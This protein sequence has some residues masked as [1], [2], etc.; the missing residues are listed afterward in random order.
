MSKE[1]EFLPATSEAWVYLS[2][3]RVMLKRLAREQV[4]PDFHYRQLPESRLEGFSYSHPEK[5]SGLLHSLLSP[6]LPDFLS[7]EILNLRK[8]MSASLW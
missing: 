3:V 1:Y 2:M 7:V 5:C 6:L 8:A 4:Q